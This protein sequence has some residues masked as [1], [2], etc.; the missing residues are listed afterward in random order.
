MGVLEG[1]ES[2]LALGFGGLRLAGRI[3]ARGQ[4]RQ[5]IR[6]ARAEAADLQGRV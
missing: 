2:W 3:K 6:H 5:P 4:H 1:W